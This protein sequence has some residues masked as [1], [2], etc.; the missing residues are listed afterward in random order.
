MVNGQLYKWE[1]T[2]A[3][4]AELRS[5]VPGLERAAWV[6][7]RRFAQDIMEQCISLL[8]DKRHREIV[9]IIHKIQG[10]DEVA[11]LASASVLDSG[12]KKKTR[13]SKAKDQVDEFGRADTVITCDEKG[14]RDFDILVQVDDGDSAETSFTT[15]KGKDVKERHTPNTEGNK[16]TKK[17]KNVEK[18][19]KRDRV[20]TTGDLKI[21][22]ETLHPTRI[23]LAGSSTDDRQRKE[24]LLFN[25]RTIEANVAFNAHTFKNSTLRQP[26]QPKIQA[27]EDA[28]PKAPTKEV[29]LLDDNALTLI[30]R[31]LDISTDTLTSS[32]ERKTLITRLTEAI[33]KDL[34]IVGNDERDTMMR[35]GGYWRYAN[36]HTYNSMVKNNEHWDWSTGQKLEELKEDEEVEVDGQA[37]DQSS[38]RIASTLLEVQVV[39]NHDQSFGVEAEKPD[40]VAMGTDDAMDLAQAYHGLRDGRYLRR[41]RQN[42]L[43]PTGALFPVTPLPVTPKCKT[44]MSRSDVRFG[45]AIVVG[46]STEDE[47][48]QADEEQADDDDDEGEEEGQST[49][50]WTPNPYAIL[51][52][53]NLS[54]NVE[55]KSR[56]KISGCPTMQSV[57][58][59]RDKSNPR[60]AWSKIGYYNS[61]SKGL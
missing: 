50:L 39:E 26:T 13:K 34:T 8:H 21:V 60:R 20:I 49:G 2:I 1:T 30:L 28:A 51:A 7:M 47:L 41:R 22:D 38:T 48:C 45:S 36:R 54:S 6:F 52:N 11:A 12:T 10:I 35:M 61:L 4:R 31:K 53:A 46:G 44:G 40:H 42:D 14:K 43:S 5:P 56:N 23:R 25:N 58:S 55:K 16:I 37:D 24:N 9:T 59:N 15:H 3:G 17:A 19:S 18:R 27:R 32:K 29:T 57:T 33:Q